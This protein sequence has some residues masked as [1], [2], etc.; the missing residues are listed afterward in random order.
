MDSKERA[1]WVRIGLKIGG[2]A[3][4]VNY[5][6]TGQAVWAEWKGIGQGRRGQSNTKHCKTEWDRMV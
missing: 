5:K 6:T 1:R 4:S 3:I 2:S